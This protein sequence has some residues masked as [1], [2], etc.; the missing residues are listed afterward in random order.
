M[1]N[2][3]F[4]SINTQSAAT[5]CSDGLGFYAVLACLLFYVSETMPRTSLRPIY[6]EIYSTGL[7]WGKIGIGTGQILREGG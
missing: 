5:L 6:K 1:F 7:K 3:V 4:I 2:N